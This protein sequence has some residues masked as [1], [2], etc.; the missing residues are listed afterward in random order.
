M[1]YIGTVFFWLCFIERLFSDRNVS[2]LCMNIVGIA[3]AAAYFALARR[4]CRRERD[5]A[6]AEIAALMKE[7][8]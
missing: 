1:I 3:L 5:V 8:E 2:V 6:Q 4:R 7:V